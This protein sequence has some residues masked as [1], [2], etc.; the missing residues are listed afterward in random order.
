M[1]GERL[2]WFRVASH[3]KVPV[4]ELAQRITQSEFVGWLEYLSWAERR[5]TKHDV[6]LAQ[7]AAEVRRGYV[8]QPKQV[9]VKDFL[10]KYPEPGTQA[11]SQGQK[12]K[13]VWLSALK[14][15]DN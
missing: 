4:E 5:E 7:I 12:S 11:A 9:R 3:L 6:Y 15:K 1:T 10:L 14:I 2:A 8:K 13:S